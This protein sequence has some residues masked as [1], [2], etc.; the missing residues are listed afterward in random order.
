MPRL[1]QDIFFGIKSLIVPERSS[2]G[3]IFDIHGETIYKRLT[4]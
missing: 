1:A 2:N 4:G 3:T